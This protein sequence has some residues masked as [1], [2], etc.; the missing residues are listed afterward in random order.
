MISYVC[1]KLKD[2]YTARAETIKANKIKQEID[3]ACHFEALVKELH[4][5]DYKNERKM[6]KSEAVAKAPVEIN[7]SCTKNEGKYSII[8]LL[9]I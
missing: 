7:F 2:T 6:K 8:H 3:Q 4:R 5:D 1:N 9:V